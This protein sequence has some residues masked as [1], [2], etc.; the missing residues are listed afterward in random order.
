[1]PSWKAPT[2]DSFAGDVKSDSTGSS[3]VKP[4]G[5]SALPSERSN[6]GVDVVMNGVESSPA[7]PVAA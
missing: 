2:R 4:V 3:E 1:M 6:S 7:P 5:S